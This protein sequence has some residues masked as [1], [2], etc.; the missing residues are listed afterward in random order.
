MYIWR[1]IEGA[2]CH[3]SVAALVRNDM[4]DMVTVRII[5]NTP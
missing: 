5:N 2:D 3:T 1:S 4:R